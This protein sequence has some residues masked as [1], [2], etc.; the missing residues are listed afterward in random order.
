MDVR[1]IQNIHKC[2]NAGN[3]VKLARNDTTDQQRLTCINIVQKRYN[4][5]CFRMVY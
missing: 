4:F 1:A 2:Q 5:R 3:Y